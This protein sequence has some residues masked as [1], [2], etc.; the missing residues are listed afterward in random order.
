MCDDG[1]VC[2]YMWAMVVV[3]VVVVVVM[4]VLCVVKYVIL[5]TVKPDCK[6]S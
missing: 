2:I 6:D 3:V 5:K 1:G 4:V